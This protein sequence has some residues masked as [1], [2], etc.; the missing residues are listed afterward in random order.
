MDDIPKMNI[1]EV[2]DILLSLGFSL[3]NN[4]EKISNR[5]DILSGI[6]TA[7]ITFLKRKKSI[8]ESDIKAMSQLYQFNYMSLNLILNCEPLFS[9]MRLF[10]FGTLRTNAIKSTKNCLV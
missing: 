9:C 4:A 10:V 8:E 3:K 7:A 5:R 6:T 2:S 1:A